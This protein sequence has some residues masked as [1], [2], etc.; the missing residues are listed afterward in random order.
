MSL[1]SRNLKPRIDRALRLPRLNL[2]HKI[3][4]NSYTIS[5]Y[6]KFHSL[7]SWVRLFE[8]LKKNKL[9][10]ANY[11]AILANGPSL[12]NLDLV[13]QFQ[14]CDVI[15]MNMFYEFKDH[16][17]LNIVA[18]CFGES[19]DFSIS[20]AMIDKL[21]SVK[22]KSFWFHYTQ[23]KNKKLH[24][25]NV[26]FYLT[27]NNRQLKKL[28]KNIDLTR[29]APNYANTAQM[30][31]IVAISMG[32]K[33]IDLYGYDHNFLAI[34]PDER[35]LEHFYK[36]SIKSDMYSGSIDYYGLIL[37]CSR[38]WS[39]YKK[40]KGYSTKNG[41]LIRNCTSGSYLDVFQRK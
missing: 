20:D 1:F 32:Y 4:R 16:E 34:K 18:Y 41:I 35:F 8:L 29:P 30:A 3:L 24:R 40:I 9:K 17:K 11:V 15:V 28:N 21:F 25:N 37:N 13:Q 12:V 7:S 26:H 19:G 36:S 33:I 10:G 14:N 31:I 5:A 6:Q 23:E 27:G 2:I 39:I 38:I 22:S